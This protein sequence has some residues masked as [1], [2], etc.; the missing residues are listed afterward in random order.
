MHYVINTLGGAVGK[1]GEEITS[2]QNKR[3]SASAIVATRLRKFHLAAR[4]FIFE[5]LTGSF[6]VDLQSLE[7]GSCDVWQVMSKIR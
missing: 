7:E 4:A 6:V 2:F 5:T 3:E 1:K